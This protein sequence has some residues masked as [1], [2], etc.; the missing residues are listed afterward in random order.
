MRGCRIFTGSSNKALASLVVENLG[1]SLSPVEVGQHINLETKVNIQ[2]SVRDHDVFIIQSGSLPANDNLMELLVLAHAC[3]FASA[4][5][6]TAIIPFF[7][8]SKSSEKTTG[9]SS[10]TAKC[11]VDIASPV[12][13]CLLNR[14]VV[15][16]MLQTAGI[17][18]VLTM[19]LHNSQ[20]QGISVT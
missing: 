14:L 18:H 10:I 1:T 6:V 13:N 11:N 3:K 9:R 20:I 17:N 8:Y 16:S 5:R 12:F 7:P 15:A 2:V 4:K 19:D